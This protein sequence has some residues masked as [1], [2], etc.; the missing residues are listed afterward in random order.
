M[1]RTTL[2]L[3]NILI[4]HGL[5]N[6]EELKQVLSAQ[7][8]FGGRIGTNTVNL[9]LLTVDQ[10]SKALA[11]QKG[12]PEATQELF[13]S[14]DPRAL[15]V[16]SPEMC[17]KFHAFPLHLQGRILHL[18]MRDPDSLILIDEISF[19]LGMRIR[20][21]VCPELRL[22]YYLEKHYEVPR[23]RHLQAYID[24]AGSD[25]PPAGTGRQ[26]RSTSAGRANLPRHGS[27]VGWPVTPTP[28]QDVPLSPRQELDSAPR[29]LRPHRDTGRGHAPPVQ[30][31]MQALPARRQTRQPAQQVRTNPDE[32]YSAPVTVSL[33]DW[34][35]PA[36]L[37][38]PPSNQGPAPLA[39]PGHGKSWDPV[40]NTPA[41]AEVPLMGRPIK[42]RPPAPAQPPARPAQ[43]TSTGWQTDTG[44]DSY[45]PRRDHQKP[46]IPTVNNSPIQL[47]DQPIQAE[48]NS[49][50]FEL[51]DEGPSWNRAPAGYALAQD[52]APGEELDLGGDLTPV[53]GPGFNQDLTPIGYTGYD[54]LA[55]QGPGDIG[56]AADHWEP[57]EQTPGNRHEEMAAASV[58]A[59]RQQLEPILEL[60]ELAEDSD[61]ILS[62]MVEPFLD[63]TTAIIAFVPRKDTVKAL[64]ASGS[65]LD[66]EAVREMS[67][68]L[69]NSPG[70][71]R[72]LKDK[73]LACV[74]VADDP[75]HEI[76]AQHLGSDEPGEVL[77][78]PVTL[79]E[80][81]VNLLC[82]QALKGR[83]FDALARS[84]YTRLA[85]EAALAFARLIKQKKQ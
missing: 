55:L 65:H 37:A 28:I 14:S 45:R 44:A 10:V 53:P 24:V 77:V 70:F 30:D 51:G 26:R 83:S 40:E 63:Y 29:R 59:V 69:N 4:K 9:N 68:D 39:S 11:M 62:C 48:E 73:A 22:A 85:G 71:T 35:I 25:Q 60:L 84:Y 58:A 15:N 31:P 17:S 7:Q 13:L 32:A 43:A 27:N 34:Q 5:L 23:E 46:A 54:D 81:V 50:E 38:D 67:F 41:P 33:D 76:I 49:L 52:Q 64:R 6:K 16:L 56:D 82:V 80:R 75:I 12:V 79:G 18:A 8:I 36:D 19:S 66:R 57:D 21:Y 20:P 61:A 1:P 74:R 2:K 72:A 78:V 47:E 3:G 42:S